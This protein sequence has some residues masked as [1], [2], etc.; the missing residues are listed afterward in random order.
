MSVSLVGERGQVT[1]PKEIR[2]RLGIKPHSAVIMEESG[3]TLVIRPART[4][5]VRV[6]SDEFIR[7]LEVEN[8]LRPGE[9]ERILA[10]WKQK[11]R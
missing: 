9:R 10:K 2:D 3:N 8:E 7:R 4:V 1:I 6:Y 11:K 5:P